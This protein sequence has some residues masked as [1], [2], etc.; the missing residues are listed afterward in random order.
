MTYFLVELSLSVPVCLSVSI[1]ISVSLLSLREAMFWSAIWRCPCDEELKSL[2]DN[3]V[4][5]L[6]SRSPSGDLQGSLP[7]Q[8]CKCN[9]MRVL[10]PQAS[11]AAP[12]F[13]TS[14]DCV[15][16]CVCCFKLFFVIVCYTAIDNAHTSQLHLHLLTL[17]SQGCG[18]ATLTA[19]SNSQPTLLSSSQLSAP[20]HPVF[21]NTSPLAQVRQKSPIGANIDQDRR[22]GKVI[23]KFNCHNL[24]IVSAEER[25]PP[26]GFS[27]TGFLSPPT[28]QTLLPF[29]KYP[30]SPVSRILL[31]LTPELSTS[32]PTSRTVTY[33]LRQW[34]SGGRLF[35]LFQLIFS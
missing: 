8:Q 9:L 16:W 1:S 30:N 23:N 6:E 14:R 15:R 34:A 35:F 11:W 13:L 32:L 3:H 21:L 29:V 17:L 25:R 18:S 19:A 4:S 10:K 22:K 27:Y 28:T 12:R 2:A 26:T 24:K 33:W 20:H 31:L 7:Q 5:K